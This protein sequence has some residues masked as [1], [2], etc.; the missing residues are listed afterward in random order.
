MGVKREHHATPLGPALAIA[1]I[2]RIRA[3][4]LSRGTH[5][6]ELSWILED[7]TGMR[8]IIEALGARPYKTYRVYEKTI[9]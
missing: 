7:N 3:F 4:H 6:A 5:M 2:D 8:R 1:V 9:A